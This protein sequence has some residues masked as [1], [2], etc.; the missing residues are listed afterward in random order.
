MNN[1]KQLMLGWIMY[2]DD[3]SDV[4]APNDPGT[5]KTTYAT[6]GAAQSTM[7][8]WVVGSMAQPLDAGD[9]PGIN[10]LSEL[11]DPNSV[12]S[13]YVHSKGVYHCPADNFL[14]P[15]AQ[16]KPHV[17]SI[18]MNSAVGTIFFSATAGLPIG[19]SVPG[20]G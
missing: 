5:Y 18:S 15:H 7:K 12:L 20:S 6:A 3:N 1:G 2:A 11:L 17:R 9:Q 10:G 14:D 4:L 8:N 19:S 13:P 16:H